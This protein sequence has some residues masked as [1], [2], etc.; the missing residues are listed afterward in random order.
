[1]LTAKTQKTHGRK[2]GNWA[3]PIFTLVS[4]ALFAVN[5]CF[6]YCAVG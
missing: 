4:F 1:M 5:V 2:G 3:D 6:S